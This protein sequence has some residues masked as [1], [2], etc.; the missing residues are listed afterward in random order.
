VRSWNTYDG[1][2][3]C[4]AR[5]IRCARLID[6]ETCARPYSPSH[7]PSLL[8]RY[9][10][11]KLTT[12][13]HSQHLTAPTARTK[14]RPRWPIPRDA[15]T[16]VAMPLPLHDAPLIAWTASNSV[17]SGSSPGGRR[18]RL[19]RPSSSS[20]ARSTIHVRVG[21]FPLFSPP[22]AR[23]RRR[24]DGAR[25]RYLHVLIGAFSAVPLRIF[26]CALT[27]DGSSGSEIPPRLLV[28]IFLS[29]RDSR[30]REVGCRRIFPRR[31]GR[32][33]A[34][35]VGPRGRLGAIAAAP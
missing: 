10:F 31:D 25:R 11:M 2:C 5:Y 29:R 23:F 28:C 27:A 18:M 30:G 19:R 32:R 17:N 35:V 8:L 1:T 12:P 9:L 22:S 6:I 34:L 4:F 33:D 7:F 14:S 26:Q 3:F 13:I 20:A 24:D 15:D 16:L 21:R